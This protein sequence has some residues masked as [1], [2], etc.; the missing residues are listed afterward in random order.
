MSKEAAHVSSTIVG[1]KINRRS[2]ALLCFSRFALS[3]KS[4]LPCVALE[5][6]PIFFENGDISLVDQEKY[7]CAIVPMYHI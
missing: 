7:K 3:E 5:K 6:L 2:F 4:P 1:D